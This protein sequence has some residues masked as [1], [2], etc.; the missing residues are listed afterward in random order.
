MVMKHL[1]RILDL[2]AA[3]SEICKSCFSSYVP[4]VLLGTVHHNS[5]PDSRGSSK[6]SLGTLSDIIEKRHECAF[7]HL[8]YS[9]CVTALP[10]DHFVKLYSSTAKISIRQSAGRWERCSS[11]E[12]GDIHS[13]SAHLYLD[14]PT[15]QRP[16]FDKIEDYLKS[17]SLT[18]FRNQ[19]GVRPADRLLRKKSELVTSK[20]GG[21]KLYSEK[22]L[23][24]VSS[25]ETKFPYVR[26]DLVR[27]W[28]NTCESEHTECVKRKESAA[29]E[30]PLRLIDVKTRSITT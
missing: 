9:I 5:L 22:R 18:C 27:S 12:T 2:I 23:R 21:E 13:N 20:R 11:L 3:D 1:D 19:E 30:M 8:Y 7:C 24:R 6:I 4:E 17:Y 14:I 28:L 25:N 10:T 15:Y 26:F 16:E 29:Q